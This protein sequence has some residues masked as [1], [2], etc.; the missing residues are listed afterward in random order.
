[1]STPYAP[2]HTAPLF[3]ALAALAPD[4]RRRWAVGVAVRAVERLHVVDL[5]RA[6]LTDVLAAVH[7]VVG[8]PAPEPVIRYLRTHLD[9]LLRADSLGLPYY[10]T[11]A[12]YWTLG[13]PETLLVAQEIGLAGEGAASYRA[14]PQWHT[15]AA[16]A[17]RADER[18]WQ[19]QRATDY[20]QPW[21][22]ATPGA[23]GVL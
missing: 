11:C 12:V 13:A 19:G 20:G 17:A 15:A 21:P 16:V 6:V 7:P 23:T 3:A 22:P 5:R 18:A 4:A 9:V 14:S 2:T 10:A 1:M 8:R